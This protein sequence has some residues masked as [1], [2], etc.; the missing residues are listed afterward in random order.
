M[1]KKILNYFLEIIIAISLIMGF[2]VFNKNE[3]SS[4]AAQF[5]A[6]IATGILIYL[7]IG[8]SKNN[9]DNLNTAATDKIKTDFLRNFIVIII[10]IIIVV[11]IILGFYF[12]YLLNSYH[13]VTN[14]H[15]SHQSVEVSSI[16]QKRT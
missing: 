15:R 7:N 14:Y 6:A 8:K 5:I 9:Q 4:S 3:L 2:F 1:N 11:S 13:S 16:K 12:F 10:S